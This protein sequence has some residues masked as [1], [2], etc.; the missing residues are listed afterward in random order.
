MKIAILFLCSAIAVGQSAKKTEP[1]KDTTPDPPYSV[2]YTSTSAFSSYATWTQKID[3]DGHYVA[4]FDDP[5]NQW[6]C[7]TSGLVDSGRSEG[8]IAFTV[9]CYKVQDIPDE[10][11]KK[12]TK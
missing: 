9:T 3:K 8:I 11:T 7:V 1:H 2:T 12:E 4:T 10:R 5:N 6:R